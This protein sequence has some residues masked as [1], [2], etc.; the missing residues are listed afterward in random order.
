MN[1]TTDNA[2]LTWSDQF[3]LGYPT[4]DDTHREFVD[5]LHALQTAA[6]SDVL[7]CLDAFQRH[8]E[9]HFAQENAWMQDTDFPAG[10]CH[11]DEHKAVLKSVAEVREMVEQGHVAIA[12]HLAAELGRWFPGHTDYM[13]S[14]LAHWM[15]KRAF[16]GKPVVF[17]RQATAAVAA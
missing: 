14:A 2:P 4:M 1:T 6:D 16:G 11:I 9:A 7:A 5:T 12:R 17:R 8:A 10:Q 13:D 15:S 3:L